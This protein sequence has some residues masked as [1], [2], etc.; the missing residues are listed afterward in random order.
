MRNLRDGLT[1][2]VEKSS[3]RT[4]DRWVPGAH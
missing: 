4:E 2:G 1:A 3:P